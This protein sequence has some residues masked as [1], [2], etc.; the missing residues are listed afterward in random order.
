MS[1]MVYG[2]S[3]E[4]VRPKAPWTAS[5]RAGAD[6]VGSRHGTADGSRNRVRKA[7]LAR[8]ATPQHETGHRPAQL[9]RIPI[10]VVRG[11]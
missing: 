3:I 1:S 8:G 10:L 6:E 11:R 9:L 5:R 7:V 2:P 4:R